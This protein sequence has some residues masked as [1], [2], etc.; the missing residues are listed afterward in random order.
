M[1]QEMMRTAHLILLQIYTS[2]KTILFYHSLATNTLADEKKRIYPVKCPPNNACLL[3]YVQMLLVA[4]VANQL[5][6]DM[7]TNHMYCM[8]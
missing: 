6:L 4:F 3:Y 2:D 5:W 7:Q 8:G 1:L